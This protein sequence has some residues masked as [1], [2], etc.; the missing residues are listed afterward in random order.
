M[1]KEYGLYHHENKVGFVKLSRSGMFYTL[2]C[3]YQ[4]PEEGI[5]HLFADNGKEKTDLGRCVRYG[6]A[7]GAERYLPIKRIGEG[8]LHFYILPAESDDIFI[9]IDDDQP[10]QQLDKLLNAR[11]A[12]QSERK[13]ILLNSEKNQG[14]STAI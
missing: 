1:S 11:F 13:G 8:Q 14:H 6:Q 5:F 4:L 2:T 7:L 12:I 10:F 9:P 3:R